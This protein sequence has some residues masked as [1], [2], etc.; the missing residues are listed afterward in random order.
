MSLE[1]IVGLLLG[2]VVLAAAG[3]GWAVGTLG[4]PAPWELWRRLRS[5]RQASE[6][7]RSSVI[8]L[9]EFEG[10]PNARRWAEVAA[11]VRIDPE[12]TCHRLSKARWRRLGGEEEPQRLRD[13]LASLDAELLIASHDDGASDGGGKLSFLSRHRG[14]T[15]RLTTQRL[16]ASLPNGPLGQTDQLEIASFAFSSIEPSNDDAAAILIERLQGLL[17]RLDDAFN[18]SN[19]QDPS[20]A[21]LQRARAVVGLVVGQQTRDQQILE[22]TVAALRWLLA[23]QPRA[24]APQVWAGLQHDLGV[25]LASLGELR[26]GKGLH[27]QAIEAFKAA[28]EERREAVAPAAAWAESLAHLS[29]VERL[30][31]ARKGDAALLASAVDGYRRVLA[32]QQEDAEPGAIASMQSDLGAAL[33]QL[34]GLK[35]DEA[36]LQEA[37]DC[38]RQSLALRDRQAK[39]M[40]WAAT[41]NNLANGL[42]TLGERPGHDALLDE[43]ADAYRQALLEWT[44]DRAPM[45]WAVTNNNLGNVLRAMGSRRKDPALWREAATLYREAL[46]ERTR[47]R[48][49][50]Q[51][52]ATQNNLGHALQLLGNQRGEEASLDGAVIAFREALKERTRERMP[53]HWAATQNNLAMALQTLGDRRRD[54]ATLTAAI[55]AYR[56]AL[57]EWALERV[58]SDWAGIQ[59]NIGNALRRLAACRSAGDPESLTAAIEAYRA[60]LQV[61]HQLKANDLAAGIAKN[62]TRAE[63]E[64]AALKEKTPQT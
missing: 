6:S 52:A 46:K 19:E 40:D 11:A 28:L 60:A 64:L 25:A 49:P 8:L 41:Q 32:S 61:L 15:Q 62:L 10:A 37:I 58:P 16:A 14:A 29:A 20:H 35:G 2:L 4:W 55:A 9:T 33:W 53:F 26:E 23:Q 50:L 1:I 36:L 63:A 51:W 13:W 24:T 57:K 18:K 44:R 5:P 17:T 7:Q 56:E 27:R 48:V 54:E 59:N 39:P 21:R 43:A 38:F 47:D 31:G 12:V 22:Q 30:V 3:Y 42:A 34:G 45:Q